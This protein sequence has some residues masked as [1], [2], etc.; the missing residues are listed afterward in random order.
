MITTV[1]W[2][3]DAMSAAPPLPGR[4]IRRPSWSTHVVLRL[5]NRSTWAPPRKPTW[6]RPRWRYPITSRSVVQARAPT[7]LGGSPMVMIGPAGGESRTTP[8]SKSPIAR[9]AWRARARAKPRRGSRIPTKTTSPS[10]ISRAAATTMIWRRVAWVPESLI[11]RSPPAQRGQESLAGA[12]LVVVLVVEPVVAVEVPLRRRGVG[13]RGHHGHGPDQEPRDERAVRVAPDDRR[14]HQLLTGH[15]DGLRS[16]RGLQ[17]DPQVP[18]QVR[19]P[20]GVAALHVEDGHVGV[21]RPHGEKLRPRKGTDHLPEPWVVPCH[22]AAQHGAGGEERHPPGRSL[23][24]ERHREV[25]VVLHFEGVRDTFLH[26]PAEVVGDPR[27]HVTH[28]RRDHTGDAPGADQLVEEDVGDRA[29]KSEVPPSLADDLMA[30]REG[31]AGLQARPHGPRHPVPDKLLD[32][33]PKRHDLLHRKASRPQARDHVAAVSVAGTRPVRSGARR[34]GAPLHPL[35]PRAAPVA[36]VLRREGG[37]AEEAHELRLLRPAERTGDPRVPDLSS[38]ASGRLSP[39]RPGHRV[40]LRRSSSQA[41]QGSGFTTVQ[42]SPSYRTGASTP[43]S[44]RRGPTASRNRPRTASPASARTPAATRG[45]SAPPS[46]G[47]NQHSTSVHRPPMISES[48][49]RIPRPSAASWRNHP[50]PWILW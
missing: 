28:P 27:A 22:V 16:P 11:G 33:R 7:M 46:P 15:E 5:P 36:V 38:A 25:R 13:A 24:G 30:R 32:G 43:A 18:P 12:G 45:R 31:D 14:V 6:T 2:A 40:T 3:S 10:R 21:H 37:G 29:D 49:R 34:G 26:R 48:W 35:E 23:E 50:C 42:R 41:S 44:W 39:L 8:F 4:R 17:R 1:R 19:V 47:P 9:G 20:V